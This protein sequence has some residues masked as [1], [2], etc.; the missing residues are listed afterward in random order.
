MKQRIILRSLVLVLPVL[1]AACQTTTPIG[2]YRKLIRAQGYAAYN[3]P[4][5]DPGNLNDWN[6]FGPGTVLRAK[7]QTHYYPA[8]TLLG[9][10]SVRDASKTAN[11]SPVSLFS[12]RRVSGS[13]FD[14]KGGWT[15]D[16]VNQIAGSLKT[17]TDTEV[18]IQFGKAWLANSVAESTLTQELGKAG[19]NLDA[20]SRRAL[21]KGEFVVVQNAVFTDSIRYFFKQSKEGSASVTYKLSAEEIASLQA[22][23][24]KVVNGAIEV[25]ERRFIAFT[26]LPDAGKR[27][28]K[29][30]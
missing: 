5:G 23:G 4:V 17:K 18:D 1:L 15:L 6:K 29:Q 12:N 21:R 19:H 26:P 10:Q 14:G 30:P 3:Q 27:L 7:Q 8:K 11:H 9:D 20:T 25:N 16:A 2:E 13:E 22:K 24:Y 28:T